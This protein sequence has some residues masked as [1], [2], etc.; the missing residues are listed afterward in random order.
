MRVKLIGLAG[1]L[2]ASCVTPPPPVPTTP[3]PVVVETPAP[4]PPRAESTQQT[5]K[6]MLAPGT[7]PKSG[8]LLVVANR[9]GTVPVAATEASPRA[10]QAT[11]D[12]WI[13]AQEVA[14]ISAGQAVRFDADTL[15]D[16]RPF[17]RIEPGEYW[18]QV[19]L[20]IDHDMAYSSGTDPDADFTSM[21]V[22]ITLPSTSP[23][24]V[25]LMPERNVLSPTAAGPAPA[26]FECNGQR[27]PKPASP[28][29]ADA[30]LR[31]IDFVSPSL[32]AFWG[33]EMHVCGIV[34]LPPG[35]ETSKD[36]YPTV[37]RADGFGSKF[38]TLI[39]AER[40]HFGL[41]KSGATPP[42][43]R[44]HLDHSSPWGTHEFADSVNNGPW[45]KALTEELIPALEKQYR[46]DAKPSGRF[47]TGHSSGGWYALWQQVR[48]P[49]VFGGTWARAPDPVDFRS[50]TGVNI[51]GHAANA[52]VR[53][54]GSAQYL[55]RDATGKELT[56]LKTYAQRERVFGDY[57]G[58]MDSF[59]WV[60]SPRGKDGRPQPL[61]DRVTGKVDPEV[62]AYWREHFDIS[63][64]IRRDWK[65]LKP[66]L[67]GKIHIIMG[68]TDTFHLNEAAELLEQELKTLGAKA[69]F[70]WVP[71]GTHFNLDRIGDDPQGLEK[72]I[73]W[74]MYAIAR[75]NSKLKP[76]AK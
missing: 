56:G 3:A 12:S 50:Y 31:L 7:D 37:Y 45:G 66:V 25:T 69:T 2:A 30:N 14:F 26:L 61:F 49:K 23:V 28:N 71:G 68:D 54:D 63:H 19:R 16:P 29:E 1:L 53:P 75:P 52:Y 74:E 27:I 73:A 58:Q 76:V 17:S 5:F 6:V 65:T 9:V 51:Y 41:M 21:P 34:L 43:I 36:K 57:G 39:N 33:R 60:F 8:R 38:T 55:V 44:V 48:Y 47:T 22:K 35:Y 64:I 4:M 24:D 40:T 32:S 18:V 13:A 67:D 70:T 20:D 15:A 10:L 72:K 42:M 59:D 46:M 62:A 11:D